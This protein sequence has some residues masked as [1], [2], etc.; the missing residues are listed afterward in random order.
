MPLPEDIV[1]CD[2]IAVANNDPNHPCRKIVSVQRGIADSPNYQV[3]EPWRGDIH[4][5]P[6]LFVASNPSIDLLDDAPWSHLPTEAISD[7]YQQRQ[8]SAVF[9]RAQSRYGVP[10]RRHVP[11]WASVHQRA[12]E[13]YGNN[14]N[15]RQGIDYAITEVVHC[16]SKDEFGVDEARELCSSKFLRSILQHSPCVF[17]VSL[18]AHAE[19]AIGA[20]NPV[21]GRQRL[22]L[23]HPGSFAIRDRAKTV[24][25][26]IEMGHLTLVQL[27]AASKALNLSRAALPD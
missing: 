26:A 7:Y 9:P 22:W 4:H 2:Q 12:I 19:A 27:Q 25:G 3:P 17:I 24:R 23:A 10:S 16:K 20:L 1:R 18:G 21:D 14:V 5:A 11:F 13:L 8:I 15:V 6:L